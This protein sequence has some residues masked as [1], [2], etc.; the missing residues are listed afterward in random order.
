[1]DKFIGKYAPHVYALMRIMVGL[2]FACH[3]GQKLLNFP[4]GNMHPP[5]MSMG[6]VG[7]AIELV[8]GLLIAVGLFGSL[9]AFIASGEMAVAY[10]TVHAHM[11]SFFPLINKGEMAVLYCFIFLYIAA[12]GSGVW[13]LD[14]LRATPN[15]IRE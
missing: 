2:L 4:P 6:G 13:S 15:R 14:S 1:M 11:G 12:R 8:G 3:G 10:F 9:A 5:L 7:G